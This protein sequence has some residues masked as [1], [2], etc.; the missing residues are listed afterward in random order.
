LAEILV[1]PQ[2]Q[3]HLYMAKTVGGLQLYGCLH[4]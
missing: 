3:N 1:K 4:F 2:K